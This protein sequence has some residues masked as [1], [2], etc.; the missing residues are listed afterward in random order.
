MDSMLR[1]FTVPAQSRLWGATI[2]EQK[3][4]VFADEG[5]QASIDRAIARSN[6]KHGA[7]VAHVDGDGASLSVVGK[8]G[9]HW[10]VAAAAYK[11]Y[12]GKLAYGAQVVFS[13]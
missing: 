3:V 6:A 10:S 5:L 4:R 8:L 7:V 1:E 2:P 11:P 13:W 12:R 9:D